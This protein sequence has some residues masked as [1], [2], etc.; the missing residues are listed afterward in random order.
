MIELEGDAEA[1]FGKSI[2]ATQ[3]AAEVLAYWQGHAG[4]HE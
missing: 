1:A 2:T 3:L 4:C